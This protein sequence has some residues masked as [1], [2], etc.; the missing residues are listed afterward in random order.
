MGERAEL[1]QP[2]P[3]SP[4]VEVGGRGWKGAFVLYVRE[5]MSVHA[6]K[7]TQKCIS[8]C[9]RNSL[10]QRYRGTT[11]QTHTG[12]W[13]EGNFLLPEHSVHTLC[14]GVVCARVGNGLGTELRA[15]PRIAQHA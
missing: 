2:P 7:R 13:F 1:L 14:A 10:G 4:H 9:T 6:H 8:I 12:A 15:T 5:C 11:T 3:H